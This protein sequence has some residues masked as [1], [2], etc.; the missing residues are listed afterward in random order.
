MQR[1]ARFKERRPV[2][3][4]GL[5]SNSAFE[6]V[7]QLEEIPWLVKSQRNSTAV[8]VDPT[9]ADPVPRVTPERWM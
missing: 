3:A 2:I 5:E 9:E 8:H 6:L 1:A 4:A 7:L